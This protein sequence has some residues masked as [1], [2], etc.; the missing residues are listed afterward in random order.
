MSDG[1]CQKFLDDPSTQEVLAWLR[2]GSSEDFRSLGELATTEESIALAMEAYQAGAA[3]VFAVEID[4]YPEGQNTGKLVIKL[5]AD[6]DAR[7]RALGWA[8][9]IAQEQG[10]EAEKDN[11]QSYLFVMLD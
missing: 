2:A 9:A 6:A 3:K 8:G 4:E 7:R 5:P 10:F 1:F 11:G